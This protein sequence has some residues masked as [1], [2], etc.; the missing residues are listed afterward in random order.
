MK[1]PTN[2]DSTRIRVYLPAMPTAD[3]PSEVG[4]SIRSHWCA[5]GPW[6]LWLIILYSFR[7]ENRHFQN[8]LD[9]I[10]LIAW[11]L[12]DFLRSLLIVAPPYLVTRAMLHEGE[13]SPLIHSILTII[14]I[15]ALITGIS[16]TRPA[17]PP[18]AH[19]FEVTE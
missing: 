16:A 14:V 6:V 1:P 13:K 15:A 11:L 2:I 17:R 10:P 3:Q 18:Q 4:R 7:G 5:F 9:S 19:P 8:W 12:L